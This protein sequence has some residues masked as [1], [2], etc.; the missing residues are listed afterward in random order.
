MIGLK[1]L[2]SH[3]SPPNTVIGI[4][5]RSS[6]NAEP[7]QCRPIVALQIPSSVLKL[8]PSMAAKRKEK[9][10][11]PPN[12]VIGIFIIILRQIKPFLLCGFIV[13][14]YSKKGFLPL[15]DMSLHDPLRPAR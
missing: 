6:S 3:C 8:E 7:P 1:N 4:E 13:K 5:T 2:L 12:T 11:S 9:D 10:C 15:S 14:L